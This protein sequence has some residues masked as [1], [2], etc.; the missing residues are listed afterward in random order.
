MLPEAVVGIAKPLVIEALEKNKSAKS[1]SFQGSNLALVD[2]LD[3]LSCVV[4]KHSSIREI[5]FEHNPR[6]D[7]HEGGCSDDDLLE[8]LTRFAQALKRNTGLKK[9]RLS[10]NDFGDEGVKVLAG[11]LKFNASLET[12][13]LGSNE[14]GHSGML[15]LSRALKVNSTLK[16]IQLYDNEIDD[17]G[18]KRLARALEVNTAL[19]EI[20]LEH[21]KIG[22]EGANHLASALKVNKALRQ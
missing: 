14:I 9:L 20:R 15:Y 12:L 13:A 17:D 6:L 1:I 8:G 11:A 19:A 5:D 18:A 21:N 2:R 16:G 3:F 7:E 10:G 22:A 4:E